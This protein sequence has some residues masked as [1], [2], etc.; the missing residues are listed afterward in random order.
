[1]LTRNVRYNNHF[2]KL[3]KSGKMFT[4][5]LGRAADFLSRAQWPRGPLLWWSRAWSGLWQRR[6]ISFPK[7]VYSFDNKNYG[8]RKQIKSPIFQSVHLVISIIL[9]VTA[10]TYCSPGKDL[11]WRKAVKNMRSHQSETT[12]QEKALFL[13]FWIVLNDGCFSTRY[14]LKIT[15]HSTYLNL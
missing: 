8:Q 10:S 4:L 11:L 13:E 6:Q 14:L 7:K 5:V 15:F 9:K 1:M 3:F 12:Q 2:R